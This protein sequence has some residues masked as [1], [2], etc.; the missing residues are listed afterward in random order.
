MDKLTRKK[1]LLDNV[2]LSEG[3][4][5]ECNENAIFEEYNTQEEN[6]S[7]LVIKVL[8]VFGGFLA[9]LA[10]LGF[11]AISGLYN[12]EFGL[13]IFGLGFII[14]AIWLNKVYDRLIIDTFSVSIYLIGFAL[15]AFGLSEMKVD[16]NIIALLISFIALSS[17][18][19]S[20]N[21]ILSFISVLVI[22]SSL[23]FLIIY[24]NSYDLIHLYISI[25][26]L[27]VTY[28][29][30]NE[31]KII[32]SDNRLSMLYNPVR[33]GLVISLLFGL[34]SV[35]KKHLIPISQSHIWLSSIVI[36][37]VTMYLV[38]T[39]VKINEIKTI[40]SKMMIYILSAL[41]LA[42]TIFSPSISGGILIVLLSFLV[43][44][45]RGLAI[46]IISIIYFIAQ[47]YYD[48]NFTLLTKSII[49]FISGII[50]LL[51]YLFTIKNLN[52][53]EKI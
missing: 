21:F 50:F 20:Q 42:S 46:G 5:F 24:N 34:I 36:I 7:S 25:N 15:F 49:L 51:F 6:K 23:I 39:I 3:A 11:L 33:I 38:Y 26:T 45:K 27:V 41:I 43:N 12:S 8:S 30:L 32:S 47:Y 17:L 22:S 44:Y 53:N 14:S 10:F 37:L 18:F 35:G 31:A 9:S 13:L 1:A 19:I 48:L 16:E 2:R 52:P 28:F 29:F 40:K 4:K